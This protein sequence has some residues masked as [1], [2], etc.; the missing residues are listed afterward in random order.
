LDLSP[1]GR[2][3][4]YVAHGSGQQAIYVRPVDQFDAKPVPGTENGEAP[5]FSPDGD[6]L[7]FIADGKLKKVPLRGGPPFAICDVQI[8]AKASWG[9]NG[10]IAVL[11]I[12]GTGLSLVSA[13]GDTPSV[14]TKLDFSRS[15][16]VHS[17]PDFLPT[18]DAVL[19][20]IWT[21]VTSEHPQIAVH[22]LKSHQQKVLIDGA[23][24]P[25]YVSTGHLVY[26]Q[27]G[28][29]FAIPFDMVN[30]ELSGTPVRFSSS[31]QMSIGE[32]TEAQLAISAT[33][34]MA[35][36]PGPDSTDFDRTLVWVNRN[37]VAVPVSDVHRPYA[38]PRISPR[39]T[40]NS[41]QHLGEWELSD[42]DL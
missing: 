1:D 19:F 9:K 23:T 37:G 32:I 25:H 6:W 42:L 41:P 12:Y 38:S 18:G 16:R 31:P 4:A 40:A 24:S 11:P 27:G 7:G 36:V 15:E 29:L 28:S 21:G 13:N 30:L 22:S 10:Y 17:S 20:T 33:G 2:Y 8:A 39:W 34:T 14:M 5:F 26:E 35:Y 3:L